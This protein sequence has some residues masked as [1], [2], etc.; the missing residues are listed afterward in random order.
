MSSTTTATKSVIAHTTT[1]TNPVKSSTPP[2]P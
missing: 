1:A 2:L